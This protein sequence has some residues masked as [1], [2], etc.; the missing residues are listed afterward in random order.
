MALGIIVARFEQSPE[1]NAGQERVYKLLANFFIVAS[2]CIYR[3]HYRRPLMP[4]AE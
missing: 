3:G 1:M 4:L 2:I